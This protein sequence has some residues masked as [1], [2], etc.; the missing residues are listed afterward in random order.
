MMRFT[1]VCACLIGFV[2]AGPAFGADAGWAVQFSHDAFEDKT[3][4]MGYVKEQTDAFAASSLFLGCH[5]GAVAFFHQVGGF[6]YGDAPVAIQ[7]RGIGGPLAVEFKAMDMPPFGRQRAIVGADAAALAE[8]FS[9]ATALVPFQI[10]A[11]TGNF[12]FAGFNKVNAIMTT[13]CAAL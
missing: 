4:P 10:E 13:E 1:R 3:Y 12:P 5:E 11:A 7:F 2:L 8:I 9:A 6:T